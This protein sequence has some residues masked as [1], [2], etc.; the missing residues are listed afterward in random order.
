MGRLHA[1]RSLLP[2]Y[3]SQ[4]CMSFYLDAEGAAYNV[5]TCVLWP[6]HRRVPSSSSSSS[7]IRTAQN[8]QMANAKGQKAHLLGE[9]IPVSIID[10]K[11]RDDPMPLQVA[12]LT[13]AQHH[14]NAEAFERL[15]S[16]IFIAMVHTPYEHIL[17]ALRLLVQPIG[18]PERSARGSASLMAAM[19]LGIGLAQGCHRPGSRAP[20]GE[21]S[22]R[23]STKK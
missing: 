8:F 19:S 13:D 10:D 1:V 16:F 17:T 2:G 9:D 11:Y 15:H 7:F 18:R 20:M 14:N 5:M 6:L 23:N 22:R 21:A 4:P 12:P 3:N